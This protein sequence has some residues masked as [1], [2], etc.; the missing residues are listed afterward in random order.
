MRLCEIIDKLKL[1]IF[2]NIQLYMK[3]KNSLYKIAL[4]LAMITILYNIIE[5]LFSMYFGYEDETI[6][7]FGFGIDSFIE[8]ISGFGIMNMIIRI[9]KNEDSKR[10]DFERTALRITGVSFYLLVLGLLTIGIYN[11]IIAHKPETTFWG[12]VVSSISILSM[13]LL[14]VAKR[15]VGKRLNSKAIIAD[16]NC[17]KVCLYMSLILL[18]SSGMYELT[19]LPYID[20]LG[21]IGLAYISFKEG[22]ECFEKALGNDHCSCCD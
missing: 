10:N 7:L 11:I 6:A 2:S 20:S 3:D 4:I 22:R 15:R 16:A 18:A 19:Q 5:G 17:T 13:L 8:V 9:R 12:I 21:C 14:I 1:W